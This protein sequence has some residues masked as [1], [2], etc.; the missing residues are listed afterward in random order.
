[1]KTPAD[2]DGL[3]RLALGDF[4]AGR[5]AL[6][7]EL[8]KAGRDKEADQVKALP[9]PS[10]PAWVVNQLHWRHKEAF[11]RLIAAGDRFRVAQTSTLSGTPRDLR[12]PFEDR[13]KA[14]LHLTRLATGIL[15]RAEHRTTPDM[16]RRV[17]KT[18]EALSTYGSLPEAPPAGRLTDDVDPPGFEALAAL[19]P[20][21]G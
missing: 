1:L 3:F 5:N 7:T 14:L 17:T 4:T 21:E 11:D 10:I 6:A 20:R 15:R 8:K 18:I 2:I 12:G 19:A 16:M 9:K 13:R